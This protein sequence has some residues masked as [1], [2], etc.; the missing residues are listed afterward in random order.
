[1]IYL[2]RLL[3]NPRSRQVQA[4]LRD[5]YQMHRT[6]SK[7]FG[8]ADDE[9]ARARC[10]FRVDNARPFAA[11]SLLSQSLL[12]PDWE[13]LTVADRYLLAPPEVKAFRLSLRGGECLA[14]RIHANPTVKRDGK[15]YGLYREQEQEAWLR[16]KAEENGFE[17]LRVLIH[18]A[19]I[20]RSRATEGRDAQLIGVTFEGALRVTDPDAL[21]A[22]A[23]N[24]I[25]SAKA[26]GFGLL[27]LARA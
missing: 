12:E 25:G 27:S 7:A 11:L 1:M 16:R 22:A 18:P 4:E 14:F 21:H 26:F 10:L 3:L 9:F 17:V 8:D 5:P 15:R 2:S 6:L 24:G 20:V 13:R 19:T 23:A